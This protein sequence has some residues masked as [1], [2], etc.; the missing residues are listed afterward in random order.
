MK[1]SLF[2]ALTILIGTFGFPFGARGS[3]GGNLTSVHDDQAKMQGSL[4]TTSNASYDVH[5]IQASSGVVVREYV[6]RAG[7]VFGVAWQGRTHPDLRQVLGSYYDQYV[8]AVQVQRAQRRGHGPV[9]IQLP[10]LVMQMGGHMGS[11]NGRAYTPQTMPAGVRAEE[12]R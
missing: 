10:G 11:L 7:T 6:S 2:I 5:E 4:R 12:I 9:S 1:P 3:L 8:Q